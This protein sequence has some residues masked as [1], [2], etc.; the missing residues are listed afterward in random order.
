MRR[1]KEQ[2]TFMVADSAKRTAAP[3]RPTVSCTS[4]MNGRPLGE[5]MTLRTSWIQKRHTII[6][7]K[8]L[9]APEMTAKYMTLGAFFL[10]AGISSTM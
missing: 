5:S 1:N 8:P 7:M 4:D 6:K 9:I 10:G 3:F 2:I